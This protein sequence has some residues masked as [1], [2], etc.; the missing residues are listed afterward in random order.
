V[1]ADLATPTGQSL[2]KGTLQLAQGAMISIRNP[3]AHESLQLDLP[4]ALE[5]LATFSLLARRVEAAHVR[6]A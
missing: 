6:E 2:Q 1:L 5:M 4:E 3:A